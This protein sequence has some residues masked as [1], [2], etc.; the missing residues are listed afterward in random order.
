MDNLGIKQRALQKGTT[1]SPFGCYRKPRGT[2]EL[3]DKYPA[4]YSQSVWSMRI[5][6]AGPQMA[7]DF[8]DN[9]TEIS[10]IAILSFS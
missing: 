5:F 9:I 10:F 8:S 1:G 3:I 2:G 6:Q 7:K 4:G